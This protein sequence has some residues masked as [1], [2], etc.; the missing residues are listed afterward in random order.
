MFSNFFVKN[1][2]KIT[3]LSQ[4]LIMLMIIL[5]FFIGFLNFRIFPRKFGQKFRSMHLY[6]VDGGA[7]EARGFIKNLVQKAT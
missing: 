5:R 4:F 6:G 3:I 2:W 7:P 1:Q